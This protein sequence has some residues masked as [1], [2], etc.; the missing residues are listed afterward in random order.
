[1]KMRSVYRWT[2]GVCAAAAVALVLDA[3]SLPEN[4]PKTAA[5]IA[6]ANVLETGEQ[7]EDLGGYM[8]SKRYELPNG[9]IID[10]IFRE[11][12]RKH[13]FG[14]RLT[15]DRSEGQI[16]YD[17][18]NGN[19]TNMRFVVYNGGVT[20]GD[21]EKEREILGLA[22]KAINGDTYVATEEDR[23]YEDVARRLAGD[24]QKTGVPKSH[25]EKLFPKIPLLGFLEH[26]VIHNLTKEY[27]VTPK[28]E[29]TVPADTKTIEVRFDPKRG[30]LTFSR[31]WIRDK[32][33]NSTVNSVFDLDGNGRLSSNEKHYL[34][35][36]QSVDLRHVLDLLEEQ[37][38][39]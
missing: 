9:D 36:N 37:L 17:I 27:S 10:L 5:E 8:V 16:V 4:K 33:G 18:E 31:F 12:E 23:R 38:G 26:D 2:A 39:D 13:S 20:Y 30:S 25:R 35:Y 11:Y 1:M 24:V 19:L 34:D 3:R 28:P 32:S 22:M 14:A 15:Q 21:K 6:L 7:K 29:K